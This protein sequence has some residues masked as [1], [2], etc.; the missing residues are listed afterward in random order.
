MIGERLTGW[1][2]DL[3]T[4]GLPEDVRADR[5]A[6]IESDLWEHGAT[7]GGRGGTQLAILS[8][9]VRG[10]LADLSWRRT[11][12]HPSR[13]RLPARGSVFRGSGWAAALGSYLFLVA[14]HGYLSLALLGLV[15]L[16]GDE[17]DVIRVALLSLGLLAPLLAGLIVLRPL[18][19]IGASLLT[20]GALGT[21]VEAPWA[22]L[23]LGPTGL[24]VTA[25]GIVLARRRLASQKG[26][27]SSNL[28]AT[29]A[30]G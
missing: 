2:T 7:L 8:R 14:L 28:R 3:Y 27:R 11:Q 15:E 26:R 19:W 25:A 23:L 10:V 12:R 20:F 24:A 9:C 18:P 16:N 1:W 21:L 6:E 4:R 29:R 17:G 30:T 22:G 5:T 13:R